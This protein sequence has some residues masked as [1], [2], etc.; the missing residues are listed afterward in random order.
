MKHVVD[1]LSALLDGALAPEARVAVES[2]LAACPACRAEQGRLAGALT[3]LARLPAAP[4][5]SPF[6]SARLAARLAGEPP[7]GLFGRL[8]A[9]RWRLAIPAGGLAAAALAGVLVIRQQ[10]GLELAA[11][12]QLDLLQ[13]YE[14][15]ASVDDVETAEDAALI[16]Q[17]DTLDRGG[18]R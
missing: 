8:A 1:E 5:P 3:A 12:A 13:E 16:A 18:G 9:W 10:R 11:A 15:I 17:L 6:F 4:G 14:T 7:R 2:H